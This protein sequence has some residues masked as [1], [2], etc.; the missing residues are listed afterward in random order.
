MLTDAAYL[1]LRLE[2]PMQSWGF[3]SQFNRRNTG[4]MPTKSAIAGMCCAALGYDR[5]SVKER[6]FLTQF[7]N[8]RMT[9]IMLTR[10]VEIWNQK[11][12][13]K[14]EVRRLTDYHTVG[15]GFDPD[16]SI[17]KP[18][19]P[20]KAA[21]GEPKA[22]NKQTVLTHRQYLTDT[23]F[24]IVL[25][26]D[27]SE[28]KTVAEALQNPIWGLW[29][30]RKNCIPTAPVFAGIYPTEQEALKTLTCGKPGKYRYEREVTEFASGTDTISDQA[31]SFEIANRTFTPRRIERNWL[32]L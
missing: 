15:G 23:S 27:K 17:E 30:G 22:R 11:D 1:A 3:D 2:G 29:L 26:G 12:K 18:H 10:E 25:A 28:I 9:A 14:L 16:N 21:D 31:V 5:G 7:G 19:I 13:K 24:G 32:T 6:S 20:V 4:L 8:F